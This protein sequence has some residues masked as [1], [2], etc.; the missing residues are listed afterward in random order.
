MPYV[1]VIERSLRGLDSPPT[2]N[3]L[4]VEVDLKAKNDIVHALNEVERKGYIWLL[5]NHL[6]SKGQSI[7]SPLKVRVW[8]HY[9]DP[10]FRKLTI[11][12]QYRFFF[13]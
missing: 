11:I 8:F 2:I 12:T 4:G 7:F 1:V 9:C 5:Y 13:R 10:H 3:I 6:V